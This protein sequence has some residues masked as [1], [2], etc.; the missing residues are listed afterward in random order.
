MHWVIA[1]QTSKES[2]IA[3]GGSTVPARLFY[4]LLRH[5]MAFTRFSRSPSSR[6][7]SCFGCL[8]DVCLSSE[9][10][11]LEYLFVYLCDSLDL[12]HLVC[13][14]NNWPN[15]R[16]VQEYFHVVCSNIKKS[17]PRVMRNHNFWHDGNVFFNGKSWSGIQNTKNTQSARR[18]CQAELSYDCS[19]KLLW[20][21]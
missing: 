6:Y 21:V 15:V 18:T 11:G 8:C 20:F 12:Y 19:R 1:E 16:S 7:I 5:L 13:I 14:H 2:S 4:E 9:Y 10:T 3:W 17:L